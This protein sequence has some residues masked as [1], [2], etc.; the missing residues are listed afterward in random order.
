D[1]LGESLDHPGH[2]LVRRPRE[3]AA[4][5]LGRERADLADLDPRPLA[6]ARRTALQGEGKTRAR[7]LTRHRQG[8]YGPRAR[9][10]D[11]L[12]D[13]ENRPRPSLFMPARRVEMGPADFASQYGRS[14]NWPTKASR[15]ISRRGP[16]M[17]AHREDPASRTS[18]GVGNLRA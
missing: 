16:N 11:V 10:E 7:L 18:P 15:R 14:R 9:V 8:D 1:D 5:P 4:D 12:A 6:E 2:F 17:I 13:H 3:P